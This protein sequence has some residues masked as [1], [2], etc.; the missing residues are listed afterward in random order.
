MKAINL[1]KDIPAGIVPVM[2]TGD[3]P[4]TANTIAQRIRILS[5]DEDLVVTG[6]ER[7][8][9]IMTFFFPRRKK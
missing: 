3:H 4:L 1:K 2:I 7:Q 8:R 6:Q 9:W 5:S